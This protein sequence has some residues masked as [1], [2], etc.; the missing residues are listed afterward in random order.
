MG[1]FSFIGDIFDFVGDVGQSII[2]V[3]VDTISDII[4]WF[5]DI[6]D[7]DDLEN[8][9]KGV[10]VN[11][12]S[13]IAARPVVY[14]QRKVG[15]TRV[16]MA[17]SGDDNT[18]L[19]IILDLCE[20]EV[21]SIGDIYINDIISTDSKFSGLLSIAKY[22]GTDSQTADSTFV[23]ANIGWTNDHRLR[24]VAYLAVR[25]KWDQE[26][27]SGI[28]TIHAIVQGRKVYDTRT[29]ATATTA[30]SSN[31]ALCLR[32]YLTNTR[33]GK[34]LAASFIDDTLFS[35]AANKCD[36]LVTSYS[37]SGTQKIFECNAVVN[38]EKTLLANTKSLLSSMRGLMLYRQ[39][40][41]GLIVEDQGIPHYRRDQHKER[42]QEN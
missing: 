27:F 41:Y 17:T 32:D 33:Y 6:P 26:T 22:V 7:M 38:T 19:Y 11:K 2:D 8:Q 36:A 28:P 15:G 16:F 29:S 10:L 20:G 31:P 5:I 42:E 39:G 12:Q 40:L 14:G 1:L 25:L 23:A 24:G 18:Y 37:G 3:V 30:L 35:A 21:H 34:G 4:G 13:N 9:Y